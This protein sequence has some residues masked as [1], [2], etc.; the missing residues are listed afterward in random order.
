MNSDLKDLGQYAH[1]KYYR[2]ERSN[3]KT[4]MER[5]GITLCPLKNII[6]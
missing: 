4:P 6:Y 2:I 3:K 1:S 5:G